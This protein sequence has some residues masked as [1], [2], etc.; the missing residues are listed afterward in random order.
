MYLLAAAQS[1]TL[2]KVMLQE[3]KHDQRG[4]GCKKRSGG[5]HRPIRIVLPAQRRK[6]C[7]NRAQRIGAQQNNGP[8]VVVKDPGKFEGS[9]CSQSGQSQRQDNL[10]V[11]LC[12]V[13]NFLYRLPS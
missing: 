3:G 12:Q 2:D 11:V 13:G 5:N 6:T 7:R 10:T 4:N 1:E 8:Q 9:Q